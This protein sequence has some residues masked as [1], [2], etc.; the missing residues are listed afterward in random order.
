MTVLNDGI[1]CAW[2]W[3]RTATAMIDPARTTI[4]IKRTVPMISDAAYIVVSAEY[5]S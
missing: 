2:G 4:E 3:D 5:F 1:F